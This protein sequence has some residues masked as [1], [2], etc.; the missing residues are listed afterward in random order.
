MPLKL[1]Y[2]G[3]DWRYPTDWERGGTEADYDNFVNFVGSVRDAFD[4][5]DGGWQVTVSVPYDYKY[6]Q[7][8]S[9]SYLER[10][11]DWFNVHAYDKYDMWEKDAAGNGYIRPQSNATLI[12]ETLDLFARNDI[13]P[14]KI[15]LGLGFHGEAYTVNDTDCTRPG[16]KFGGPGF[17]GDCTNEDGMLFYSGKFPSLTV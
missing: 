4:A 5:A 12:T 3:T 16:C 8:Y 9:L 17:P 1:T 7:G 2:L 14:D 15:V 10:Q 11:V 6:L 13:D